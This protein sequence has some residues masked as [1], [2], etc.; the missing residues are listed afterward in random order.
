MVCSGGFIIAFYK[1]LWKDDSLE[2]VRLDVLLQARVT[3][4]ADGASWKI[5]NIEL[6]AEK[7][8]L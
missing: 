3:F 1:S 7:R 5:K 4:V 8:L 6:L 2:K